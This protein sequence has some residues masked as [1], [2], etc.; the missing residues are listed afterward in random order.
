MRSEI[1]LIVAYNNYDGFSHL[2]FLFSSNFLVIVVFSSNK[3]LVAYVMMGKATMSQMIKKYFGISWGLSFFLSFPFI[4]FSFFFNC[5]NTLFFGPKKIKEKIGCFKKKPSVNLK[6][7][8]I[9]G[10]NL[11]K[12]FISKNWKPPQ[13]E[14]YVLNII[15]IH[16]NHI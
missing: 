3:V 8:A 9:F 7:I 13:K 11:A 10:E 2:T 4:F 12:F 1:I 6:K 16:K 5:L 15:K 14:N